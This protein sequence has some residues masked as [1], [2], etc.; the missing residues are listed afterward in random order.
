MVRALRLVV[1]TGIH[2]YGWSYQKAY[3]YYKKYSFNGDLQIKTQILRYI[4]L[5]GQALCYK[6]GEKIIL[7]LKKQYNGDIKKFHTKIL[8]NGSIPLWLLKEQFN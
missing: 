7:D 1:D 2:Y 8:E 6:M 5:P 3:D 4:A